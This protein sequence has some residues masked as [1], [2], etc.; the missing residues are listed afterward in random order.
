MPA[1]GYLSVK[2]VA[3]HVECGRCGD[4]QRVQHDHEDGFTRYVLMPLA[5]WWTAHCDP[6]LVL[7]EVLADGE[8]QEWR[9]A[10]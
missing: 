6:R 1:C 5:S 8:P 3:V 4:R 2:V 7:L 9:A 10:S